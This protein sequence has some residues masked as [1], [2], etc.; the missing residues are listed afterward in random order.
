MYGSGAY[1]LITFSLPNRHYYHQFADLDGNAFSETMLNVLL[2]FTMQ[3]FALGV[4][5]AVYERK[6]RVSGIKQIAFVL[7]KQCMKVQIKMVFWMFYLAQS[8]LEHTGRRSN[9]HGKVAQ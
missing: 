8:T 6:F 4:I 1:L 9:L 2:Y 7:E 3:V 5:C